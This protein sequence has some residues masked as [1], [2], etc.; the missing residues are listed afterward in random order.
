MAAL[1]PLILGGKAAVKKMNRPAK[2]SFAANR[3]A[4]PDTKLRAPLP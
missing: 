2:Q 3:W 4:E 1:P